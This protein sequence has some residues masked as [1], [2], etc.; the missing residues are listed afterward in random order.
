MQ[1]VIYSRL[2]RRQDVDQP[3]RFHPGKKQSLD[4]STL[5]QRYDDDDDDDRLEVSNLHGFT[6]SG[7][8]LQCRL[9]KICIAQRK[10]HLN[11]IHN[12]N[13]SVKEDKTLNWEKYDDQEIEAKHCQPKK[14]FGFMKTHKTGS[15]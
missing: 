11:G 9:G 4:T 12:C 15:R 2:N 1:R 5:R 6:S 8:K 7:S 14:K 3:N 10:S 13:F